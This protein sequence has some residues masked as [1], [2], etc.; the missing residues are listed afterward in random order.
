MRLSSLAVA[1]LAGL[2]LGGCASS[3]SQSTN[4]E[5]APS[6]AVGGAGGAAAVRWS[7]SFTPT[8]QR[9]GDM[10][11]SDR[12]RT[13]GNVTLEM[14]ASDRNR[15]RIRMSLTVP[16]TANNTALPWAIH[17]GRCGSGSV[18]VMAVNLFP[19]MEVGSNGR[20]EINTELAF[21]TPAT[22]SFHVNVYWP[23]GSTLENVMTCSNLR[24]DG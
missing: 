1:G 5:P 22:G 12:A 24:R 23:G 9:S 16:A 19:P 3:A 14:A 20:A 17:S 21:A 4:T 2:A 15:S 8:Q 18:P 10:G 11:G 6:A 7:G 13:Y